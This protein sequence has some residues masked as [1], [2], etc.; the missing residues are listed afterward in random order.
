M[1]TRLGLTVFL[2][3]QIFF[4]FHLIIKFIYGQSCEAGYRRVDDIIYGG[5]CLPCECHQHADRC[6]PNSG[7]CLVS[8]KY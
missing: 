1:V 6:D 5:R 4:D 7:I 2:H 3:L 8:I